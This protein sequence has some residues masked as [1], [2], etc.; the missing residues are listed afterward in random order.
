MKDQVLNSE[1]K[2][3]LARLTSIYS[4]KLKINDTTITHQSPVRLTADS[5]TGVAL[6][7]HTN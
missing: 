3:Y 2:L 6:L 5:Q 1:I 7:K 4:S